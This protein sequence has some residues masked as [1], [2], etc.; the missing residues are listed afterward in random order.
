MARHRVPAIRDVA[1]SG[2]VRVEDSITE[3]GRARDL[4]TLRDERRRHNQGH[5]EGNEREELERLHDER[6]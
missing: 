2:H 6:V 4:L 3:T 1:L 5:R